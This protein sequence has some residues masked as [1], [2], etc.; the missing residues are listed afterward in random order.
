M[1]NM[2]NRILTLLV[3]FCMVF[4]GA[5]TVKA[6]IT[7]PVDE[8]VGYTL[9]T[10]GFSS[11]KA[12]IKMRD[13][14]DVVEVYKIA[15]M[16]WDSVDNT[17]GDLYW[18]PAVKTWVVNDPTH[19]KYTT[20]ALLG[21][22]ASSVQQDFFKAIFSTEGTKIDFSSL[23]QMGSITTTPA[24]DRILLTLENYEEKGYT[25][26]AYA[27]STIAQYY[28]EG[29]TYSG[30]T[31][32]STNYISLG[33]NRYFVKG[34]TYTLENSEIQEAHEGHID[35]SGLEVGMYVVMGSH[36]G[37]PYAPL[38]MSLVPEKTQVG[39]KALWYLKDSEPY[40]M[41]A[42]EISMAKLI[43]NKPSDEVQIGETVEFEIEFGV[44][45]YAERDVTQM[46]VANY[47]LTFDDIL[48]EA[49]T[50]DA[51]SVKIQYR[52]SDA[53]PWVD[54]NN[55]TANPTRPFYNALI[56]NARPDAGT[57]PT[58]TNKNYGF[59]IW[60]CSKSHLKDFVIY[61]NAVEHTN[62][63]GTK[64][65]WYE[66]YYFRDGAYHLIQNSTP[67][68]ISSNYG[69][70]DC[71]VTP[72]STRYAT[73]S[74]GK[75][76]L[77]CMYSKA[78]GDNVQHGWNTV[79]VETF[80][81]QYKDVYGKDFNSNIFNVT[82]N[83]DNLI[84][85]N[86]D[87]NYSDSLVAAGNLQLRIVYNAVV[88]QD[89]K[90]NSEDN[91]NEVVMKYEA[92]SAGTL[93]DELRA[94]VNAYTYTATIY[95]KDGNTDA[96]LSNA[97]F[98]LY[99]AVY[100]FTYSGEA[101]DVEKA[102][103]DYV[104]SGKL[105]H[106]GDV[107]NKPKFTELPAETTLEGYLNGLPSGT[108]SY[109]LKN[110]DGTKASVFLIYKMATPEKPNFFT[111]SFTTNGTV[112][113]N[114][115]TGLDSGTYILRETN[116]PSSAYNLLAEDILFEIKQLDDE[117]I[118]EEYGGSLK[119]FVDAAGEKHSD[120][121]YGITVLN[122]QGVLLPS[123][124]GMG[125]TIFI[126]IGIMLMLAAMFFVVLRNRKARTAVATM[127]ALIV[128][129]VTVMGNVAPV[130]ATQT[131]QVNTTNGKQV[132]GDGNT[133]DFKILLKNLGDKVEVYQV[134]EMNWDEANETYEDIAWVYS[135]KQ[136]LTGNGK[137]FAAYDTPVKLGAATDISTMTD[138]WDALLADKD[139]NNLEASNKVEEAYLQ[140]NSDADYPAVVVK[141]RSYGIYLI[142][143]SNG[144]KYY[145]PLS[146]NAFPTQE[147]P[148]GH[149][150]LKT[151]IEA[152]LKYETVQVSKTING[153]AYDTV[154]IDEVVKFDIIGEVP[155]YPEKDPLDTTKYPYS[156]NDTMSAAF[157]YIP[158][159]ETV[160]VSD[161]TK[162]GD[163]NLIWST[164]DPAAYTMLMQTVA[165]GITAA[166]YGLAKVSNGADAVYINV[167]ENG[168]AVKYD[169]YSLDPETFQLVKLNSA[170]ITGNMNNTT[171]VD[172]SEVITNYNK[173][174]GTSVASFTTKSIANCSDIY[175]VTFDYD[176]LNA[177]G[178]KY[179]KLSYNAR[180]T[181]KIEVGSE[182]NTNTANLYYQKNAGGAVEGKPST[183]HAYTYAMNLKKWDGEAAANTPLAGAKFTLY[184]AKYL[185]VPSSASA[186]TDLS[187]YDQYSFKRDI[188]DSTTAPTGYIPTLVDTETV[189]VATLLS[190]LDMALQIVATPDNKV[191][192]GLTDSNF[193]LRKVLV[194]S[195]AENP[196]EEDGITEPHYHMWIC[197]VFDDTLVSNSS[198]DGITVKGLEPATYI[199]RE[200]SA[201]V[202]Y[203]QLNEVVVF[204]IDDLTDAE[205]EN[206]K[207][208]ENKDIPGYT[209][210]SFKADD[211]MVYKDGTYPL[212]VTN[213]KG[214]IL[215]S[216]GG[217]GTMIFTIIGIAVMTSVMLIV[218]VI[219]RKK[220]SEV[221]Y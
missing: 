3:A 84:D 134:A 200:T 135:V 136:W 181:D 82:F 55:N 78:T 125:T 50:L 150:F 24:R 86:G 27:D 123:T 199:L 100:Q 203:N 175:N 31:I 138:F 20:P 216:T 208:V 85:P 117:V 214:A 113:G 171:K 41:K 179:V 18:V 165:T 57:V 119:V 217:T 149:F 60:Y 70:Y 193:Y 205:I 153:K 152:N 72:S 83:Y 44:P 56:A 146:V 97:I 133:T 198:T 1:K 63:N 158:G 65:V 147:G 42:S 164:L 174:H 187:D 169:V 182:N 168:G 209:H 89:A 75:G 47:T 105:D 121:N 6:E 45:V 144:T 160:M 124:G 30:Q 131:V 167:F 5:I 4:T 185:Y 159:S 188:Y 80:K 173:L 28:V 9:V 206:G 95:K 202:G 87:K 2:I 94:S 26:I 197:P 11:G 120:G 170:P 35:V 109:V 73:V 116:P 40:A 104:Y 145:Q 212:E 178:F 53:A 115:I 22:A 108:K 162:D 23:T 32:S 155:V 52:T 186:G 64:E 48:S 142:V 77:I 76:Q 25:G 183:V 141:D 195:T 204:S 139:D 122:Y 62:D 128:V 176:T 215:P 33:L 156:I 126:I 93:F 103:A 58:V 43:N 51:S 34:D 210:A 211:A 151:N 71:G 46:S 207:T 8:L 137:T 201:P 180:I 74:G 91:I 88:D 15:A 38:I 101:G 12:V 19:S 192:A 69:S 81:S 102:D 161:G 67:Q 143:G 189:P 79:S 10:G 190:T 184:E 66:Y 49:F 107:P 92:N 163:G 148:Y 130:F 7:E 16:D 219:S 191:P 157:S 166:S 61:E 112:A 132:S 127:L 96:P 220:R 194:E 90:A 54:F 172:N 68:R 14:S 213:F 111:G 196:C 114:A 177:G 118:N 106:A 17:F 221:I 154:R 39:N 37:T 110:D 21:A 59:T 36:N 99:K 98:D 13:T 29:E 129:S 140:Y 218:I